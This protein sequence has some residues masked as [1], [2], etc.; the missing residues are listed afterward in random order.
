MDTRCQIGD[1]DTSSQI[2]SQSRL[3][4][5]GIRRSR[6]LT[7]PYRADAPGRRVR[8][9]RASGVTAAYRL[10]DLRV[11]MRSGVT[12]ISTRGSVFQRAR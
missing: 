5:T 2:G 6:G 9:R 3:P 7:M 1:A 8:G 10:P 4:T 11:E 12:V